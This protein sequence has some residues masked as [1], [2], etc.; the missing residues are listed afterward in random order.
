MSCGCCRA[1]TAAFWQSR[2]GGVMVVSRACAA[3]H[4]CMCP[5]IGDTGTIAY[6]GSLPHCLPE[7]WTPLPYGQTYLYRDSFNS[8]GI[9]QQFPQLFLLLFTSLGQRVGVCSFKANSFWF[10]SDSPPLR[11]FWVKN[12]KCAKSYHVFTV[13][14]LSLIHSC[15]LMPKKFWWGNPTTGGFALVELQNN[16]SVDMPLGYWEATALCVGMGKSYLEFWSKGKCICWATLSNTEQL[17]QYCGCCHWLGL[18]SS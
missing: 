16:R 2:A 9:A 13:E 5:W 12:T 15:V 3:H 18:S 8:P 7:D 1:A 6:W 10:W 4:S 11:H 17:L 14:L